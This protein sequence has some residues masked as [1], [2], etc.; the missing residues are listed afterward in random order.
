MAEARDLAIRPIIICP[1][2]ILAIIRIVSVNGRIKILTVSMT[3]KKG[4]KPPGAP[5]GAKCAA[6]SMGNFSHPEKI[7]RLQNTKAKDAETQI[8]LV[9]P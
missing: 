9:G 5:A 2:L 7:N 6:D 3:T 8:F 1:A 4:I